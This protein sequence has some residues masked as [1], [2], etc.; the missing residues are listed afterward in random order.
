[1]KVYFVTGNKNKLKEFKQILGFELKQITLDL[2]EIQA[3]EVEKVVEHKAREAFRRVKNP[4]IVEDTGL[5]FKDW[6]N[7]P[8]ALAKFFDKTIGYAILCKLLRG[9]R[10]ATAETVIG[11]FD[12]KRYRSFVGQIEGTISDKA[13]GKTNFGWDIIFIPKGYK[14]TFAEMGEEKNKISMRKIALEKLKRFLERKN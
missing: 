11:Y 2:D 6:N 10:E 14:K 12:G 13:K 8:G 1:M 7:L 5:Y 3:I 4:V 9:S